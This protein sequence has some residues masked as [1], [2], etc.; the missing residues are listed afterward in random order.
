MEYGCFLSFILNW[1][2]LV[3]PSVIWLFF[4]EAVKL[5][6]YASILKCYFQLIMNINSSFYWFQYIW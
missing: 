4:K 2:I 5:N 1:L 3:F 6:D